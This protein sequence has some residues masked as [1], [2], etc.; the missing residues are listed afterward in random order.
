MLPCA[1]VS[2]EEI[3]VGPNLQGAAKTLQPD[4]NGGLEDTNAEVSVI[5]LKPGDITT[6]LLIKEEKIDTSSGEGITVEVEQKDLLLPQSTSDGSRDIGAKT[7]AEADMPR[8]HKDV[9]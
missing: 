5:T 8:S 4:A 9:Q 3:Q 6:T 2:T 1:I 7:I